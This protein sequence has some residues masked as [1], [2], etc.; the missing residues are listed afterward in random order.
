M[1]FT[2]VH[3]KIRNEKS[4]VVNGLVM[5]PDSPGGGGGGVGKSL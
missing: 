1:H 3:S 2:I 4:S 5:V